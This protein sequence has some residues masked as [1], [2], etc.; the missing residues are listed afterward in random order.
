MTGA[1]QRSCLQISYICVPKLKTSNSAKLPNSVGN[2]PVK[3]AFGTVNAIIWK[4]VTH[5]IIGAFG[6]QVK[7]KLLIEYI[8]THL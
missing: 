2:W 4:S 5:V 7:T 1:R 3:L 8:Y 6:L